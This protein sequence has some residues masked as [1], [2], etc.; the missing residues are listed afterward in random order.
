MKIDKFFRLPQKSILGFKVLTSFQSTIS[1]Y[2][3]L[4]SGWLLEPYFGISYNQLLS[5]SIFNIILNLSLIVLILNLI[6]KR[7]Q[8]KKI[9]FF[10]I[11]IILFTLIPQIFF[12]LFTNLNIFKSLF[13]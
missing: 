6:D 1:A 2:L 4:F 9:N 11:N 13:L 8:L 5:G 12:E 7:N 10:L 3:L